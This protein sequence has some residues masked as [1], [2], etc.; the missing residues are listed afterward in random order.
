MVINLL[1]L[2]GI[3]VNGNKIRLGQKIDTVTSIL[4]IPSRIK[5]YYYY[6]DSM[7]AISIDKRKKILYNNKYN[8]NIKNINF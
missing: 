7:I 6:L 8:I 3:E 5:N 1:F 4:G 2:E